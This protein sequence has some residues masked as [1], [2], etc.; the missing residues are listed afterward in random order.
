M[1]LPEKN[2]LRSVCI[3]WIHYHDQERKVVKKIKA[4]LTVRG[5]P[6]AEE[7]RTAVLTLTSLGDITYPFFLNFRFE[8]AKPE[9]VLKI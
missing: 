9:K 2:P 6:L 3:S 7:G 8:G 4:L 5:Q 1:L